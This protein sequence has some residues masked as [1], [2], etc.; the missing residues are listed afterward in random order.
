MRL[1]EEQFQALA[2]Y[3]Q[4]F[5]TMTRA[6]Y[7]RHP[8]AAALNLMYD[9]YEAVTGV[10]QRHN[11]SCSHCIMRIVT[12]MGRIWLADKQERID[13]ENDAKAV[14]L[15][16]AEAKPRRKAVKAKSKTKE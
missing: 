11:L 6:Q 16:E 15:S 9:I 4:N 13:K 10:K 8:G 5:V 3:E 2:P 14:K 1:T 12:D 7:T